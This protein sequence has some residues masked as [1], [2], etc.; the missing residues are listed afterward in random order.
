[1]NKKEF[2]EITKLLEINY[3]KQL[4]V[5]ILDIWYEELKEYP[6]ERYEFSIKQI[7]KKE[8]F[9]PNLSKV[10]DYITK[11]DWLDMDVPENSATPE[12]IKELEE[13]I[14]GSLC[15]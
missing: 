6:K 15:K 14:K 13:R 8:T 10:F 4:D 5:K 11:P 3:S 7:I 12:E 2:M 1:M 9:M